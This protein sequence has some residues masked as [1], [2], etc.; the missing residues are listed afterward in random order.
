MTS[1]PRWRPQN[2]VLQPTVRDQNPVL[3]LARLQGWS[4]PTV[5]LRRG[6]GAHQVQVVVVGHFG[7]TRQ[8]QFRRFGG[9]EAHHHAVLPDAAGDGAGIHPAD[10][11]DTLGVQ[12]LVQ[13]HFAIAVAGPV[14]ML[15]HNEA[16]HLDALRLE[17]VLV[18]AVVP[19]QGIG[20]GD[21]LPGVGRVGQHL[22]I[23]GH[24]GIEDHLA[25]PGHRRAE[26][27]AGMNR[28]VFQY[29]I[30]LLRQFTQPSLFD[31]RLETPVLRHTA[32]PPP[33]L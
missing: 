30:G 14:A 24:A 17:I 20:Q 8:G 3:D 7:Q 15:P 13:R 11:G 10:A 29:Q 5:T 4:L 25:M 22:L 23:P 27:F 19:H 18:D 16:R 12:E 28:T 9:D 6:D 31:S 32:W 33:G 1:Q 26:G 2:V 21:Q